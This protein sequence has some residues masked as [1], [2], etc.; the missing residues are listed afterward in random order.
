MNWLNRQR[1]METVAHKYNEQH[2]FY[3]FCKAPSAQSA[4]IL[5]YL[6]IL[7]SWSIQKVLKGSKDKWKWHF[8]FAVL[9]RKTQFPLSGCVP[10]LDWTSGSADATRFQGII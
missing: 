10:D 1:L 6:S 3:M 8:V 2:G 9:N 7:L 5:F 4:F